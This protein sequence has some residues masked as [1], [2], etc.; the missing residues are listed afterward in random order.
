MSLSSIDGVMFLSAILGSLAAAVAKMKKS[1]SVV[2][3]S[4]KN[5]KK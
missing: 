3:I 2:R 1:R 4:L 5:T